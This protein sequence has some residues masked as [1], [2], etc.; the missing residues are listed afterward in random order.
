MPN[1]SIKQRQQHQQQ[2]YRQ[3]QQQYRQQ[4]QQYRQQQQG[5]SG[6]SEYVSSVAGAYGSHVAMPGRGNEIQLRQSGGGNTL[7]VI[8]AYSSVRNTLGGGRRNKNSR[9]SKKNRKGGNL[10]AMVVP[11]LFLLANDRRVSGKITNAIR[12]TKDY[13]SRMTQ[14]IRS[15]Y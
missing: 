3:Q 10:G 7:N 12:G 14:K 15:M 5:G 4:Q 1:R 8:P 9:K 6:T 11:A 2:Q 13:A